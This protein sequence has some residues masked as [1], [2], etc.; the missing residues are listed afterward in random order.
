MR[1]TVSDTQHSF[2]LRSSL[3]KQ[4]LIISDIDLDYFYAAEVTSKDGRLA[5]RGAC[6]VCG[7]NLHRFGRIKQET[8]T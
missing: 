4:H 1:Y 3:I 8:S 6:E 2:S 7:T 5:V